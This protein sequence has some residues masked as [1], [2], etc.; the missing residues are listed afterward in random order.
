MRDYSVGTDGSAH[1]NVTS[2]DVLHRSSEQEYTS[3]ARWR[4]ATRSKGVSCQN[5]R[6]EKDMLRGIGDMPTKTA[7]CLAF[8]ALLPLWPVSAGIKAPHERVGGLR[9]QIKFAARVQGR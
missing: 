2:V 3:G 4:Q 9:C 5:D 7:R 6:S 8:L 1:A